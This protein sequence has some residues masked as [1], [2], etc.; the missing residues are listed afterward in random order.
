MRPVARY[1]II[2]AAVLVAAWMG[3]YELV[4]GARVPFVL[5]RWTGKVHVSDL[6]P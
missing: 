4:S 6:S 2:I 3:R 1:V 5:D